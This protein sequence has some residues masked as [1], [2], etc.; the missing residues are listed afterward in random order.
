MATTKMIDSAMAPPEL[1][2]PGVPL[3]ASA[4]ENNIPTSHDQCGG[5]LLKTTRPGEPLPPIGGV[6]LGDMPAHPVGRCHLDDSLFEAAIADHWMCLVTRL[7]T[8]A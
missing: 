1:P 5:M 4:C 8:A 3:N 2:V 7:S 6:P